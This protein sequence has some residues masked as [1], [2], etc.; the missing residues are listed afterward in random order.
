MSL[1]DIPTKNNPHTPLNGTILELVSYLNLFKNEGL[2]LVSH[3]V[4]EVDFL[5][6]IVVVKKA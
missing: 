6:I 5:N 4:Y 2:D 1:K 3:R